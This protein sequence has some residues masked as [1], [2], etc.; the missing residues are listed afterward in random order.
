LGFFYLTVT[1][2][3]FVPHGDLKVIVNVPVFLLIEVTE[4][5]TKPLLSPFFG[6]GKTASEDQSLVAAVTPSIDFELFN[7]T[8]IIARPPLFSIV[9]ADSLT[10][11]E[12]LASLTRRGRCVVPA[13]L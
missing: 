1:I 8:S 10:A 2:T 7:M 11:I 9:R 3:S 6:S 12:H 5:L 4:K 13:P